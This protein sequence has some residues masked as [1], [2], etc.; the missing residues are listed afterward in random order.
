MYNIGELTDT[1]PGIVKLAVIGAIAAGKTTLIAK[2]VSGSYI[3]SSMT[4]GVDVSS[5]MIPVDEFTSIETSLFEFDEH[6][7]F[8]FFEAANVTGAK[9]ALIVFD[10]SSFESLLAV[11]EWV[12]MISNIP[13]D[14][15]LFVGTKLD[16]CDNVDYDAIHNITSRHGIDFLLVSSKE[17]TNIGT[18]AERLKEMIQRI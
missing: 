10:C 15:K 8:E 14:R 13:R 6:K 11:E 2:L 18:L 9:I 12:G 5:W 7:E 16:M 4:T 17:G 1:K 3:D